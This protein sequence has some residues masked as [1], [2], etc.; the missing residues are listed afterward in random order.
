[1]GEVD[2][3]AVAVAGGGAMDTDGGGIEVGGGRMEVV[4][5]GGIPY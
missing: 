4:G 2:A 1:M 3:R 5:G